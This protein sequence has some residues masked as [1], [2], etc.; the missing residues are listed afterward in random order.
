MNTLNENTA[1]LKRIFLRIGPKR[2]SGLS[3]DFLDLSVTYHIEKDGGSYPITEDLMEKMGLDEKKLHVIAS[4]NTLQKGFKCINFAEYMCS[5]FGMPQ[6]MFSEDPDMYILTNSEETYG[7][8]I[9]LY[10]ECFRNLSDSLGGE[11]LIILPSSVHEL[12]VTKAD[13]TDGMHYAD[14]V[15]SVNE[16]VVS[17]RDFLSNNVY[18]YSDG[19]ISILTER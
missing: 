7:S 5:S 16:T 6:M 15:S 12:I 8:S 9:L 11:D 2:N 17:E 3:K 1:E 10:P 14:I 18:C 19:K 13:D 4:M